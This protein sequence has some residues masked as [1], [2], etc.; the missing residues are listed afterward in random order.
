MFRI[1]LKAIIAFF[2]VFY[3]IITSSFY[4]FYKQLVIEDAKQEVTS[5]LKTTNALRHYIENIQKPVIYKLQR[6]KKLYEDFFDPK[7]LSSSYISRKIHKRYSDIQILQHKIPYKYKL[8]A[9]NP[10]NPNNKADKFETKILNQFRSGEIKEFST[11][12]KEKD[13]EYFFYC[14]SY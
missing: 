6:D 13:Q 12:L 4:S 2:I 11:I 1:N 9:T 10:R 14:N 8:A 5:I 3:I 7:I